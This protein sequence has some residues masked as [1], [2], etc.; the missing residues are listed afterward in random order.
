MKE[1]IL[2]GIRRFSPKTYWKEILAVFVILLAFVFFRSERKE[3][4]SIIPQLHAANQ[5]WVIVGLVVCGIYVLLQALMYVHSFKAMGMKLRLS[6]AVELFLKRNFLSVFLPAGGIS[7]LAYTTS[8]L[9]KRNLNATQIHQASAP[10][11]LIRPKS[12][13]ALRLP[14]CARLP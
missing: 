8:Q 3:L 6:D 4:K 13:I 14:I 5:L 11:S 2:K 12:M 10:R 9:R 7:S 1:R